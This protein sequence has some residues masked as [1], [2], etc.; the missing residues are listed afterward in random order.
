MQPL[1]I[2]LLRSFISEQMESEFP[3][4]ILA[5]LKDK[6]GKRFDKRV[7]DFLRA[8]FPDKNIRKTERF[9][10]DSI[11]YSGCESGLTMYYGGMEHTGTVNTQWI[12]EHNI[13]YFKARRERNNSRRALLADEYS[14]EEIVRRHKT[15]IVAHNTYLEAVQLFTQSHSDFDGVYLSGCYPS[16]PN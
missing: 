13:A 1:T 11:S 10:H 3:D 15:M 9:N 7:V 5:A 14:M 4:E 16:K 2:E 6:E 12:E 8:K